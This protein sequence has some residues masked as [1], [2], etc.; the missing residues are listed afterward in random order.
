MTKYF[1]KLLWEHLF[2][3]QPTCRNYLQKKDPIILLK[4]RNVIFMIDDG[5]GLPEVYAAMSV[6]C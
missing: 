5:K 6:L 1:N 3:L 4:I 2:L